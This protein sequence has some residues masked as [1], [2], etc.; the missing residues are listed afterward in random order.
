MGRQPGPT[1]VPPVAAA[2]AALPM[3]PPPLFSGRGLPRPLVAQQARPPAAQT[4][5]PSK[6]S[7][8]RGYIPPPADP[9][10]SQSFPRI[11]PTS[12]AIPAQQ[13]AYFGGGGLHGRG[14]GAV[15]D[16]SI[17]LG[18][19]AGSSAS[20][21]FPVPLRQADAATS[22]VASGGGASRTAAATGNAMAP[23]VAV[24]SAVAVTVADPSGGGNGDLLLLQQIEQLRMERSSQESRIA[25]L[26]ENEERLNARIEELSESL[27]SARGG[28]RRD[29]ACV[30]HPEIYPAPLSLPTPAQPRS[31][32][33]RSK[34]SLRQIARGDGPLGCKAEE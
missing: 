25:L 12:D 20:Q 16:S 15:S 34:S 26:R 28:W 33:L 2:P 30:Q 18:S 19:M 17:G 21:P 7:G 10:R 9:F 32:R 22:A 14:V 27:S 13:P 31:G 1:Y 8:A 11:P 24:F 6:P 23:P 29:W 5:L 3:A 4:R